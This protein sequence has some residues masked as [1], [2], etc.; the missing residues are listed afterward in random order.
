LVNNVEEQSS[1]FVGVKKTQ[2]TLKTITP[3]FLRGADGS[4]PELR[5]PS[6]KGMMRF[7]WRAMNGHLSL[8]VLHKEEGKLFGSSEEGVGRSKFSLL[9]KDINALKAS[10]HQ[11]LPNHSKDNKSFEWKAIQPNS[12][13]NCIIAGGG[14]NHDLFCNIFKITVILG[15]LGARSR[16][17]FGSIVIN[18]ENDKDFT[19][20]YSLEEIRDLLNEIRKGAFKV[21]R[22]KIINNNVPPRVLEYPYIEEIY[23]GKNEW[24]NYDKLL[25]TIAE[26]AHSNDCPW[27][28]FAQEGRLASPIY[29]SVIKDKEKYKPIITKLHCAFEKIKDKNNK[30]KRKRNDLIDNIPKRDNTNYNKDNSSQFINGILEANARGKV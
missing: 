12:N 4:T 11:P 1:A 5:P 24:L 9:I 23:V 29:V 20:N 15:G 13:F 7:W 17:G 25:E 10:Q 3:M 6:I 2:F 27:T 16:R 18:K 22:G 8:E 28:G 26:L 14:Y 30:E 19:F 21:D